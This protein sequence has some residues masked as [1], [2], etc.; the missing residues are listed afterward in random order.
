VSERN[1][2]GYTHLGYAVIEQAVA[3]LKELRARGFIVNNRPLVPWP[4]EKERQRVIG[5]DTPRSV[6]EL[7][8]WFENMG[9]ETM[10]S[11]LNSDIDA[12]K[13]RAELGV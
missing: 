1:E 3:D 5:Y 7:I 9:L 8:L 13:A 11:L 10:L 2:C 6:S 4:K 12:K